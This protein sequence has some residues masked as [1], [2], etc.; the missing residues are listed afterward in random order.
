MELHGP[1]AEG[2]APDVTPWLQAPVLAGSEELGVLRMRTPEAEGIAAEV[3]QR[4]AVLVAGI[5]LSR[6]AQSEAQ[7]RRRS[8]LL[9]ELLAERG[10]PSAELQRRAVRA[11]IAL[12]AEL[13][14]LVIALDES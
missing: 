12:D 1:P 5:L 10:E 6:Q 8:I 11:G 2:R 9:E 7:H 4:S 3:L 14:V 13:V